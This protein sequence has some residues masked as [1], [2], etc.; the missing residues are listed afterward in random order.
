MQFLHGSVSVATAVVLLVDSLHHPLYR[1]IET[2]SSNMAITSKRGYI[3]F[4]RG[5]FQDRSSDRRIL[6]ADCQRAL[7][8]CTCKIHCEHVY[9]QHHV[10]IHSWIA[11][12]QTSVAC[13]DRPSKVSIF[14]M[15][16]FTR[17]RRHKVKCK[18]CYI[19]KACCTEDKQRVLITKCMDHDSAG[20]GQNNFN[21]FL[22]LRFHHTSS[23]VCF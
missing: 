3:V 18:L 11:S 21:D 1:L 13:R 16:L 20:I 8:E 2:I 4:I 15:R 10:L 7:E 14:D 12:P 9:E 22:S 17:Q 5:F 19:H 23:L 6:T